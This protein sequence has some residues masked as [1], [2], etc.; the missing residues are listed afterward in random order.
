M[1]N[2]LLQLQIDKFIGENPGDKYTG[3]LKAISET[4]EQHQFETAQKTDF[5]CLKD[6]L[7][8]EVLKR[9]AAED[10]L[11]KFENYSRIRQRMVNLCTWELD[12]TADDLTNA[13]L[14]VSEEAGRIFGFDFPRTG[15]NQHFI[16]SI[17]PDDKPAVLELLQ[18]SI[19]TGEIYNKEHR[20]VTTQ[21]AVKIVHTLGEVVNDIIT[22]KPIRIIGVIQ[23][24]TEKKEIAEALKS[25]HNELKTLFKNL[26]EAFFTVDM[27]APKTIQVSN[28]CEEIFGYT[29]Q[30]FKDNPLLWMKL[31]IEEDKSMVY[32]DYALLNT[33]KPITTEYRIR[34]KTGEIRW[35]EWNITPTIKDGIL[36]RVDGVSSDIT[37][38]KMA[39][40][41]LKESEYKFRTLLQNSADAILVVNEKSEIMF[42]SDS[43]FRIAGYT[44][45]ELIGTCSFD[46]IYPDDL[47]LL[48]NNLTNVLNSPSKIYS[49]TYRRLKKDGT[50][51][52]CEGIS[53]NLLNDPAIK[54][55][56]INF[57]NITERTQYIEALTQSNHQLKKSNEELDRFVY[58]VSHDLRAPLSSILGAIEYSETETEDPELLETFSLMKGSAKKLD[59]FILDLLDYS[60]NARLD[61]QIERIDIAGLLD[62]IKNH[63]KYMGS[64]NGNV[65]IRI[66]I[67]ATTDFYS[68][69][70]RLSVIL[71]NL[72][73]NSIRYCKADINNPCVKVSVNINNSRAEICIQDN[74]IGIDEKYHF[75]I[76]D[77]FYRI[78][79]KSEGSGLGLYIVKDTI[80]KLQ[81]SLDFKSVLHQGTEFNIT[82]PNMK[83]VMNNF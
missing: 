43:I 63:L 74:G 41:A 22:H 8:Q 17:H 5:Q 59:S 65:E 36:A 42:A 21:G 56:V 24:I 79:V 12:L 50:I 6:Q 54:G 72:I 66:N 69:K 25:A 13:A 16:N 3:L 30:E 7:E 61:L 34:H 33:G 27:L 45:Q 55:I 46:Y 2:K 10:E 18:K 20:I 64:T 39:E 76:F 67:D 19:E 49:V 37:Q 78:S 57:K 71:N 14:T 70:N 75:K 81:G 4:Y 58:R 40:I 62:E 80:D 11:S 1:L 47:H 23:E 31:I 73:S 77:M 60:K 29:V 53:T 52:W 51:I 28:A 35:V 26:K 48:E 32:G 68:D 83:S 38:R 44:A 15:T 9:K 82:I